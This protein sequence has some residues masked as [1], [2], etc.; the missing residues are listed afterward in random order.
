[1]YALLLMMMMMI[2]F[3][4][5]SKPVP[6]E[7]SPTQDGAVDYRVGEKVWVNGNKPGYVH[8]LGDT[9]FAP[10]QWVGIVLDEAIGKNDG[11]VAGVQYFQCEDGRGIFTRPS[12]LTKTAMPERE[13]NGGQP[14]PGE[15]GAKSPTAAAVAAITTGNSTK[16][17]LSR[18]V[19]GSGSMSNLSETDSARKTRREL[20]LGDRVLVSVC[21]FV[22]LCVF[23]LVYVCSCLCFWLTDVLTH[24]SFSFFTNLSFSPP[25]LFLSRWGVLRQGW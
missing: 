24:S 5:A 12:K 18:T 7:K 19:T 6:P 15:T 14:N 8:F 4:A 9:Q 22:C 21:L 13:A 2:V 25:P 16:T 20:R 10:G 3:L 23:M 17:P 11:S 1:M